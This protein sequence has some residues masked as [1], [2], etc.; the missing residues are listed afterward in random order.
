MKTINKLMFSEYLPSTK[1]NSNATAFQ[2]FFFI[3][4]YIRHACFDFFFAM[5]KFD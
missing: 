2:T 1:P 5:I 4:F 3:S